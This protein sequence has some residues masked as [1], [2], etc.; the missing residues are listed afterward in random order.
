MSDVTQ[1]PA[2]IVMWSGLVGFFMPV[3]IAIIVQTGWSDRVKSSVAF[4]ACLVAGAGT[5]YFS[6][7]FAGRDIVTCALITFT[8]A[9]AS[10]A[11]FWKPTGI[12]PAIRDATTVR[13]VA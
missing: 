2:N 4:A 1:I 13:G 10:Y 12:A 3:V 7:H 5:A 9:A 11:A 6:G 8:L